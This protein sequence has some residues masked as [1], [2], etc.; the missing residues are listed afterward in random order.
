MRQEPPPDP[1]AEEAGGVERLALFSDAVFAIAMTLLVVDLAR[2]PLPRDASAAALRAALLTERWDVLAY[3]VSFLGIAYYWV[4]HHRLL[5]WVERADRGFVWRNLFV[6]LAIAF[7]PYP[8]AVLGD[9]APN[10]TAVA[11]Y[12]AT[13]AAVG[14]LWWG[15]WSHAV[16]AGL[17]VPGLDPRFHAF[18]AATTLLP[19]LV[20]LISIGVAL[21]GFPK[22]AMA[23]WALPLLQRPLLVRRYR[24]RSARS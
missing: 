15:A 18:V 17:V 2:P 19:P 23:A 12:A 16:R 21:A 11:F 22:A 10:P 4:G 14:L 5:R 24:P 1:W 6:L 8:T 9:F 7:V 13:L 3:A 20:F